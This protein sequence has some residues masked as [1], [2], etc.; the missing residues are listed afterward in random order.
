MNLRTAERMS[1]SAS[2]NYD[3]AMLSLLTIAVVLR[4]KAV[5][6]V[7]W[8][9]TRIAIVPLHHNCILSKLGFGTWWK[10]AAAPEDIV[11]DKPVSVY[12]IVLKIIGLDLVLRLWSRIEPFFFNQEDYC[13]F[14]LHGVDYE[15]SFPE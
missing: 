14:F 3:G 11:P 5:N 15:D 12:M 9:L 6:T 2:S 8:S 7:T 4:S 13:K 10:Q 1:L